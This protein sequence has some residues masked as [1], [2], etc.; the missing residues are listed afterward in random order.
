MLSAVPA[1]LLPMNGRLLGLRLDAFA[2]M[3]WFNREEEITFLVP[4]CCNTKDPPKLACR[5]FI[6]FD[7]D[8]F[9][10]KSCDLRFESDTGFVYLFDLFVLLF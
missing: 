5:T 9:S 4:P 7:R 10:R 8:R 3:A 2:E 6:A 1:C